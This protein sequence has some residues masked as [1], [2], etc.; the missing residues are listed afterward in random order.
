[1]ELEIKNIR[2][3]GARRVKNQGSGSWQKSGG[4]LSKYKQ[5]RDQGFEEK[6]REEGTGP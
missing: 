4:W 6:I 5:I 3:E 2:E 1:M